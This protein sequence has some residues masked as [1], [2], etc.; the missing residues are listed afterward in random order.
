MKKPIIGALLVLGLSAGLL[1]AQS[2]A[3]RTLTVNAT[4]SSRYKLEMT[5]NNV[6]FTRIANPQTAPVISQNESPITVT[7]KATTSRSLTLPQTFNLRVQAVGTLKDSSTG[8]T[9][10]ISAITW[11]ATGSG[12]VTSGTLSSSAN[13]LLGTWNASGTY[14]GTIKFSFQ[15]NAN[16]APGTYSLVVTLSVGTS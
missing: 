3:T 8:A 11:T 9:I 1:F 10:P 14:T 16:Y 4:V 7:V 6:T 12:F 2:S 15:D 5:S 13:Q